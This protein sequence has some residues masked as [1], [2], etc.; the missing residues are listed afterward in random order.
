MKRI[1]TSLAVV[2]FM[3]AVSAGMAQ[4]YPDNRTVSGST[5]PQARQGRVT[6]K[7]T[8][9]S[10]TTGFQYG[11]PGQQMFL[12]SIYKPGTADNDYYKAATATGTSTATV[13]YTPTITKCP[14]DGQ[15][16]VVARN[17]TATLNA[18]T[19]ETLTLTFA[20]QDIQGRDISEP[21]AWTS[22]QSGIKATAQA[23]ASIK[24]ATLTKTGTI[25]SGKT[26]S[27]GFG[28]VFGLPYPFYSDLYSK[29]LYDDDGADYPNTTMSSDVTF[30]AGDPTASNVD[31][32][33]TVQ[34]GA[35]NATGN[36]TPNGTRAYAVLY[37][38]TD[39][40]GQVGSSGNDFIYEP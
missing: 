21:V 8:L 7:S 25:A 16:T 9:S 11:A 37:C 39:T 17:L 26:I 31:Q 18:T 35:D 38:V 32:L 15:G 19:T 40:L 12:Y 2:L 24:S 5:T 14:V 20:G 30:V 36:K 28:N 23:F 13:T 10:S 3:L 1:L 6:D 22:G 29:A 4:P 27:I 34:L 33:G